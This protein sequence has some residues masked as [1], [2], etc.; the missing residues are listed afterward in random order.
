MSTMSKE[1]ECSL[2]KGHGEIN[3][4]K[5]VMGTYKSQF[6]ST[7]DLCAQS[8]KINGPKT[9]SYQCGYINII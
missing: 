4:S 8:K 1:G 3:G 2:A 9:Y 6:Q 7:N 5:E